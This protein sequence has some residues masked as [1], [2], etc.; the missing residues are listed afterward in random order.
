MPSNA[1]K[2]V[3]RAAEVSETD[4]LGKGLGQL[5]QPKEK[6]HTP[7]VKSLEALGIEVRVMVVMIGDTPMN[8]LVIPA[9]ELLVR[10]YQLMSGV[11]ANI[12]LDDPTEKGASNG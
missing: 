4:K 5:F 8:C 7:I 11:D 6:P 10:E 12:L 1:R 3:Q 9:Q 2:G